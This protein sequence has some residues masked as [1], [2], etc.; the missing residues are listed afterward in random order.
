VA[1]TV[2]TVE[3]HRRRPR[4]DGLRNRA[5]LLRSAREQL[6]NNGA[7]LAVADVASDAGVGIGTLYRNFATRDELIEAALAD[8][9]TE[10]EVEL[11]AAEAMDVAID[12]LHHYATALSR[13]GGQ[14]L[15]SV[16]LGDPV[17]IPGLADQ[18]RDI[19]RR[20]AS[21]IKRARA[22]GAL[23]SDFTL[24]DLH[25]FLCAAADLRADQ[26]V[27]DTLVDRFVRDHLRGLGRT[28]P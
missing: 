24:E 28:G 9:L 6:W 26:R 12:A 5:A 16:V 11:R 23:R 20:G 22:Q 27:D 21:I 8:L 3:Q 10:V 18:R 7:E 14:G 25:V 19:R 15:V 2:D 17:E 13:L 1:A 4:A